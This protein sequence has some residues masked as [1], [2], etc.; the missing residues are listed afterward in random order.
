MHTQAHPFTLCRVLL[1]LSS[2]HTSHPS[3]SPFKAL[4]GQPAPPQ[5]HD[6]NPLVSG[7]LAYDPWSSHLRE[8]HC[9]LECHSD[10]VTL[11]LFVCP[12]F[13]NYFLILK[14][15][16]IAYTLTGKL[17]SM[18][19]APDLCSLTSFHTLLLY[20]RHPVRHSWGHCPTHAS[21][22]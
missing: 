11:F 16:S 18:S 9:S 12:I 3:S 7:L 2:L 1:A 10:D 19:P 5:G 4:C 6:F 14:S 20:P 21:S 17:H 15:L 13:C 22:C 8:P